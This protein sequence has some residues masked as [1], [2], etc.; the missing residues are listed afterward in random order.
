M[1]VEI[2]ERMLEGKD[3]EVKKRELK[4]YWNKRGLFDR[5]LTEERKD[6][7]LKESRSRLIFKVS[8]TSD[9]GYIKV[10]PAY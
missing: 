8:S 1:W 10:F 2:V 5:D 9:N 4:K 6:E 7:D 3:I